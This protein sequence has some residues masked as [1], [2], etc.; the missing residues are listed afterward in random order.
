EWPAA[1]IAHVHVDLPL[2]VGFWRSVGH[3]HQA[4][5][6]EGFVDECAHAAGVDPLA[7]RESLLRQH[8]KQLAVLQAAA[9]ASGWG[10]PSPPAPDGART[11]RGI[12]LHD[13]FGSSV[14]QVAEVSL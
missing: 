14:A 7:F 6:K 10:T 3:S 2:Q 8:P 9:K 13:S 11:A 12:A 5:F 4:F 1:R